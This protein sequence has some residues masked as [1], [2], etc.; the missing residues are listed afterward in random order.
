M[1][2]IMSCRISRL[3]EAWNLE[4]LVEMDEKDMDEVLQFYNSGKVPSFEEIR[5]GEHK[6]TSVPFD[7]SMGFSC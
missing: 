4:E 3:C 5:F 7:G 1:L 6:Q 2:T